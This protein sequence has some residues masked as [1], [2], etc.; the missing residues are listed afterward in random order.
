MDAFIK[1]PFI[2]ALL[3]SL[4]KKN[5]QSLLKSQEN[6]QSLLK[7]LKRKNEELEEAN[8]RISTMSAASAIAD[9]CPSHANEQLV[10][11][12]TKWKTSLC[13]KCSSKCKCGATHIDIEDARENAEKIWNGIR[14]GSPEDLRQ[15][16]HQLGEAKQEVKQLVDKFIVGLRKTV[17][18]KTNTLDQ[19]IQRWG[20]FQSEYCDKIAAVEEAKKSSLLNRMVDLLPL[21][22][23]VNAE[24]A[25][26]EQPLFVFDQGIEAI[27]DPLLEIERRVKFTGMK[28]AQRET[29]G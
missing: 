20:S 21:I 26:V 4:K 13:R 7:S 10:F 28:L 18:A 27:F 11:Y 17:A 14:L 5:E 16:T 15:V 1:A 2:E 8:K 19:T 12:C 22:E 9:A 23:E 24:A 25:K 6:E 3:K 29:D